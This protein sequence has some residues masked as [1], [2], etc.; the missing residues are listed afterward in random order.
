MTDRGRFAPFPI[1]WQPNPE[2]WRY[3]IYNSDLFGCQWIGSGE[4]NTYEQ[5]IVRKAKEPGYQGFFYTFPDANEYR[6]NDLYKPHPSLPNHWTFHGR[7]DDIIVFSNGEKLNPV[8]I[9]SILVDHPGVKG[10]LVVGSNRFQPALLLETVEHPKSA[11]EATQFIDSVWPLV[12]KANKETVAHGQ[13]G[14]RFIA[15]SS[16][17]KPFLRAPKGTIQRAA[18]VRIYKEEID[19]IYNRADEITSSEAPKLNLS[20]KEALLQSIAAL[21]EER[22]QAPKLEPDMD[23]FTA[24]IDSMQ[25]INAS[26]LLRA[27]LEG[28]GIRVDASALATRVIYGHPTSRRL[29]DYLFSAANKQGQDATTGEAEQ[30]RNAMEAILQKYTRDMPPAPP[31]KPPPADEN[32]V[33]VITG[34]TG[35][36]GSYMLELAC[37]YPRVKTVICLNRSND[38]EERQRKSAADRGLNIDFSKTEFLNADMSRFD[39]GLGKEIYERLLRDVDRVI[40][41]QWPVNFN[42]PVESFEPHIRGVRNL[43]DFSCKAAKRVPI[44]FISSV[45]TVGAWTKPEPVPEES[46]RDLDLS[47]GGYGMSKLVSSLILEKASEISGVPT[48]IIR[49]GQIAGPSS[50]K[51][52]WNR[53]EWL[54]SIIASSLYLGVLPDSLGQMSSVDWTP[55]EGIASMVLEVAG[56][57]CSVALEDINGYFHGINPLKTDWGTLANAVKE[58]YGDRIRKLVSLE[59]W[60]NALEKSQNDAEDIS[61]NPGVKL[62]DTYKAWVKAAK[63]GQHH[64]AM[65][66]SRTTTRSKAMREMQA[67]TPELMKNWCRQWGF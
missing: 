12:V 1:Y 32:Q 2:L 52:V 57:T 13:I 38:A 27:G 11:E 28:A 4:E 63:Q 49:V 66:I 37:S 17:D 36:L 6:T 56:V 5:V 61:K 9:E 42:I 34:T 26:R 8:S 24:G 7:A 55:I 3:F 35:G 18:T 25:V 50:E 62:L 59:E 54:P 15:L 47:T 40:H 16:P 10:A 43:A 67:V 39:L 33:I 22:L 64:V 48:E 65:E 46:L 53:Q 44:V 30:E 60:V 19:N 20:S 14:R 31:N 21:F 45:A 51:G 41:N 29:A 23:F 58:F